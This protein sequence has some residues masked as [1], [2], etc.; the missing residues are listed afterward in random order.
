MTHAL[1][2]PLFL[3]PLVFGIVVGLHAANAKREALPR[4]SEV[5]SRYEGAAKAVVA[6]LVGE[7][8]KPKE[9]R[10]EIEEKEEGKVLVFHLWHDSAFMP[11]NKR[12]IGNPGGKCRDIVYD[13]RNRK[14]S[15]SLF[16]Q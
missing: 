1:K 14:A 11:E 5:A 2:L 4:L 6:V 12:V 16:W 7:K 13:V 9:F 8:E 15:Q 3:M 10:A